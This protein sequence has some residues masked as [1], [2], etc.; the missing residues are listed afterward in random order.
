MPPVWLLPQNN[1]HFPHTFRTFPAEQADGLHSPANRAFPPK[2]TFPT[3]SACPVFYNGAMIE[4]RH[5]RVVRAVQ[6]V[7]AAA[8]DL[9]DAERALKRPNEKARRKPAV[10]RAETKGERHD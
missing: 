7:I 2:G 6:R 4:H 3:L 10:P 1:S 5:L 9:A 8:K